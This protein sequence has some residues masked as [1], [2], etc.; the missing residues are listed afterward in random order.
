MAD[1]ESHLQRDTVFNSKTSEETSSKSLTFESDQV[2][3]HHTLQRKIVKLVA[4]FSGGSVTMATDQDGGPVSSVG[5]HG[6]SHTGVVIGV[7]TVIIIALVGA[8]VT[9]SL[10]NCRQNGGGRSILPASFGAV[11]LKV[12]P[13][14]NFYSHLSSADLPSTKLI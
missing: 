8:I 4:H 12:R 7:M 2:T 14:I 11:T 6:S 13:L 5:S 1:H 10:R 9:M 3:A